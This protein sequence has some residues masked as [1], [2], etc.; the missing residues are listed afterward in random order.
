[1]K[2]C[3]ANVETSQVKVTAG[4]HEVKWE[5]WEAFPHQCLKCMDLSYWN[6][7]LLLINTWHNDIFKGLI[8]VTGFL[9]KA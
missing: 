3:D 9:A 1:M 5:L 7:S 8:K 2:L 4:P 6:L